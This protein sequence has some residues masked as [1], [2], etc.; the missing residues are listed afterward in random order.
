MT[1]RRRS[2][3]KRGHRMTEQNSRL[4]VKGTYVLRGC[5][6]CLSVTSRLQYRKAVLG[7]DNKLT[8]GK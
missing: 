4:R 6:M 2:H 1:Y 8:V 3:C 7:R 5:R